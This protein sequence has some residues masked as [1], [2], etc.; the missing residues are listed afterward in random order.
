M[1]TPIAFIAAIVA[2]LAVLLIQTGQTQESPPSTATILVN[3]NVTSNTPIGTFT[4]DCRRQQ[5]VAVFWEFELG[6]SGT[7]VMGLRFVPSAKPDKIATSP[8]LADGYS[9]AIAANGAT[10][11]R[12]TTNF[13][14]KGFPWLHC[15]YITNGN[16]SVALTNR[17]S[18]WV[19]A[20][21]P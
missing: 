14:V 1:K 3:A 19:K 13:N 18:Y 10:T 11:V 16:A 20:D 6:G 12:V 17:L 21:A 15:Y 4:I 5:N 2:V 8:T 7:E 9:M